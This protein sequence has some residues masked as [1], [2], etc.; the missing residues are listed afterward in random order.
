MR[1][2][3]CEVILCHHLI[4]NDKAESGMFCTH[5]VFPFTVFTEQCL[6]E[7]AIAD[8]IPNR[9]EEPTVFITY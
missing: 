7:S 8:R 5:A 6:N 1:Y 2:E 4:D 3:C 9:N